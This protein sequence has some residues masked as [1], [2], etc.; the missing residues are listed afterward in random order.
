VNL[1]RTNQESAWLG[2]QCQPKNDFPVSGVNVIT[3]IFADFDQLTAKNV[4]YFLKSNV[5]VIF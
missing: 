5:G 4:G 3:I 2:C 1:N